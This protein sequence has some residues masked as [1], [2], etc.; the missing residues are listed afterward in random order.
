MRS[1][2]R[3]FENQKIVK[4]LKV[5]VISPSYPDE[6]DVTR[7]N[8]IHHQLLSYHEAALRPTVLEL[9]P[10]QPGVREE[11][12]QGIDVI[13]FGILPR[14]LMRSILFRCIYTH[15]LRRMLR[16][17]LPDFDL[18]H[19]HSPSLQL[20]PLID[21]LTAK[22]V[23]FTCH[24]DEV[25]PSKKKR[26]EMKRRALLQ[27]A[28]MATGVSEYTVGLISHYLPDPARLCFVPNGVREDLFREV[29]LQSPDATRRALG[30]PVG[31]KIVLMACN[32]IERKGVQEVLRAFHKTLRSVPEAFFVIVGNGPEK[33]SMLAYICQHGFTNDVQ[34]VDYIREDLTMARYYR[35][36]DLYVMFSKT[37]LN[38]WG[39][40]VEGF[41]ISYIDANAAGVPV[42]GGNS[43]GVPS[44]VIDG[45]TGFL[46]DPADPDPVEAL[47]RKMLLLL[48]DDT[49][50]RTLGALGQERVFADLTWSANVRRIRALYDRILSS[51]E[52]SWK[53]A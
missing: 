21:E 38:A 49:V 32:L 28:R 40:G 4:S 1:P 11:T 53:P 9:T 14:G 19:I 23:F 37:V 31:R 29:N 39:A 25:F 42:I 20:Y 44:A 3:I 27:C 7:H 13:R 18:V 48:T 17:K 10:S 8:H 35:A 46:V 5:L 47:H 22:P 43:G 34:M 12:F 16:K 6:R 51:P 45:K 26:V 41:G 24:G 33:K 50:R 30:L 2:L 52:A 36:C 15:H